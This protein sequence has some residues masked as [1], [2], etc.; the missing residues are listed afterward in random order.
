M[1]HMGAI[2]QHPVETTDV[3]FESLGLERP[4]VETLETIGFEHPTKIQAAVIPPALAGRDV[5]GLAMT[6]SGK[7]AAFVLPLAQRL[8]HGEGMRGLILSPTREI[9]LQTKAFLDLFGRDHDLRSACLIGGVS[10]GPQLQ[11]LR[12]GPDLVVATPGRLLDHVGRRNVRLG[13]VVELVI[14]EADHMLDLGFMPQVQRVLE[15]LPRE[16]RTM[17]FSATMPEPVERLANR[18]L[19]DPLRFDLRPGT[20]AAHGIDHELYLVHPDD[21]KEACM[22]LLRQESGSTLVFTRRKIDAEWLAKALD[23]EGFSVERIHGDLSQGQRVKALDGLRQGKH[24]ILVATDVAA[25]GIDIPVIEH[26]INFDLPEAVE[27]YI[28][29]AGRTA[30]G[31]AEGTV[32]SL[33]TWKDKPFL[34]ELEAALG[35]P[36]PRLRVA[37]VEPYEELRTHRPT[38]DL[39][40]GKTRFRRKL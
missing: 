6:G 22:A 24:R 12:R 10:Y 3:T 4:L 16:R 15:L 31:A 13:E 29:R 30:R 21:K 19:H 1:I 38:G 17:L 8:H 37:G 32:S 36:L 39:R 18:F 23:K 28:H 34:R 14:D 25:R 26:I 40:K 27:D 20:R 11:D 33:A 5:V 9:A 2:P 35:A 7:T